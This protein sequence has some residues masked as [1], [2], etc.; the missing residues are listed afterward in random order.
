MTYIARQYYGDCY[1]IAMTA[2]QQRN[3][4]CCIGPRQVSS[5]TLEKYQHFKFGIK[6]YLNVL[7]HFCYHTKRNAKMFPDEPGEMAWRTTVHVMIPKLN[8]STAKLQKEGNE[9]ADNPKLGRYQLN[10]IKILVIT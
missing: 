8:L 3:T 5:D 2:S 6:G 4:D 9:L 7:D 10:C 1:E